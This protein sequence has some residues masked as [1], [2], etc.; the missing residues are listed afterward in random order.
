MLVSNCVVVVIRVVVEYCSAA[1]NVILLRKS[2]KW[3]ILCRWHGFEYQSPMS[4]QS[5]SHLM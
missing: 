3:I 4:P 2:R 1:V 5:V